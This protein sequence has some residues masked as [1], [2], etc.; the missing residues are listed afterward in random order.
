MT[1]FLG[2]NEFWMIN[3]LVKNIILKDIL[4]FGECHLKFKKKLD[5]MHI[6]ILVRENKEELSQRKL[7]RTRKWSSMA[8]PHLTFNLHTLTCVHKHFLKNC[9]TSYPVT[10]SFDTTIYWVSLSPSFI[11][12]KAAWYSTQWKNCN[13][14]NHPPQMNIFKSC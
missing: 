3:I 2:G 10:C 6:I 5:G 1:L 9:F 8:L 4:Q 12:I 13:W 14:F 7:W 11:L